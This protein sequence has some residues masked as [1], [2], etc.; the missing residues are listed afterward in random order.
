MD[1]EITWRYVLASL[2]DK[3]Y[4]YAL[5]HLEELQEHIGQGNELPNNI[6][7]AHL[8]AALAEWVHTLAEKE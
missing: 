7:P 8:L 3:D 1:P 6:P 2:L 5:F 4:W